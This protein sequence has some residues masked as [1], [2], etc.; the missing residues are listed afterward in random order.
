MV[1]I[2]QSKMV[3]RGLVSEDVYK[4]IAVDAEGNIVGV[5]KGAYGDDDL[6]KT[7]R[8][9]DKGRMLAVLTDPEDVFGNPHHMGAAELAVRLGS[10]NTFDRRGDTV[11]M[12]AFE[13]AT[14]HWEVT[15]GGGGGVAALN[16]TY[17]LTGSQA[18]KMQSGT[19]TDDPT[20]IIR[21]LAYPVKSRIGFEIATS[22]A[23]QIKDLTWRIV[24]YDGALLHIAQFNWNNVSDDLSYYDSTNNPQV[25]DTA[26]S[27]TTDAGAFNISKMVVDFSTKKYIRF[28]HN[29]L[30]YDLS[31]YSYYT[32]EAEISPRL[33]IEFWVDG[34]TGQDAIVYVD[35]VIITQ[36]EP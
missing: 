9:D 36:N 7:L 29:N 1:S 30:E 12:D 13:A 34:N 16:T 35:N 27:Y 25:F 24:L 18:C 2:G 8:T 33:K 19:T 11:W 17:V 22:Y 6:L 26:R 23:A 28:I 21:S 15:P 14:L 5:F 31:A 20:K 4:V 3:V 32:A 10:I